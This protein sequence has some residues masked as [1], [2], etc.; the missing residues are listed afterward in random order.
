MSHAQTVAEMTEKN[1]RLL[2]EIDKIQTQ[3]F[4]LQTENQELKEAMLSKKHSEQL[5]GWAIDRALEAAKLF[6][7]KPNDVAELVKLATEICEGVQKI[8]PQP[9]KTA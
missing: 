4:E 3:N 2:G 1:K 9:E 5:A 8:A 7:T 6:P